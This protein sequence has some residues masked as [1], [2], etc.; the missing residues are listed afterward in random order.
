M[1]DTEGTVATAE[2]AATDMDTAVS[3]VSLVKLGNMGIPI[4]KGKEARAGGA[5]QEGREGRAGTDQMEIRVRMAW[6]GRPAGPGKLGKMPKVTRA[7]KGGMEEMGAPGGRLEETGTMQSGPRETRE[8]R[9]A[10]E[11]RVYSSNCRWR[12][13][14]ST[15]SFSA[16]CLN[17]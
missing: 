6:M 12:C 10:L 16:V 9:G 5:G 1:E 17:G 4:S 7:E 2:K 8:R 15:V 11:R 14:M 3:L 13:R